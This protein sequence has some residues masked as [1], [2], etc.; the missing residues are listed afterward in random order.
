M[1]AA[2]ATASIAIDAIAAAAMLVDRS[3]LFDQ[4]GN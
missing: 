4:P 1:A 2:G 3:D